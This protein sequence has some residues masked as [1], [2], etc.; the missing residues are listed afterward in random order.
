MKSVEEFEVLT[1]AGIHNFITLN[2]IIFW[3]R[4]RCYHTF[5]QLYIGGGWNLFQIC[6]VQISTCMLDSVLSLYLILTVSN[7]LI[8]QRSHDSSISIDFEWPVCFFHNR[9][10]NFPLHIMWPLFHSLLFSYF[11]RLDISS[12][13][14]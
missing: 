5:L 1:C 3:P 10:P 11:E 8:S 2:R 9:R 7:N 13:L 4:M 12:K 6:S 14:W